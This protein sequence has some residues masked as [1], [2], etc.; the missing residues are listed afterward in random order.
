MSPENPEPP[1]PAGTGTVVL[2]TD[3]L[4]L[5]P[6]APSDADEVYAACQDP[7]IQRWTTVPSPYE[8]HHAEDFLNRIVAEGWRTGAALDFAVRLRG[9]GPLLG[10]AGVRR[11]SGPD[12]G[13]RDGGG[14][15]ELGFWT[16]RE[17]RGRGYTAEAVTAL[18]R[19][20]L[21][22][23]DCHRL[24]WWAEVGNAGSRAVA[25]RAG[26]RYEGVRRAGLLNHGTLRDCWIGALLPGDLG[27]PGPVAYLPPRG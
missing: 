14:V 19:W 4:S 16:A 8:R 20:T 15:W 17:H 1:G 22:E 5:R 27:L 18:A 7:D 2:I 12:R 3:R 9:G 6:L 24:E 10:A 21:A 13:D 23:R 11:R 26:F 25:E